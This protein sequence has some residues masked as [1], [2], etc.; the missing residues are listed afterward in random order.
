MDEDEKIKVWKDEAAMNG[1]IIKDEVKVKDLKKLTKDLKKS[2]RD[3]YAPG[4]SFIQDQ[5][6][7]DEQKAHNEFL[8]DLDVVRYEE[9]AEEEYKKHLKKFFKG[10]KC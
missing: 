4:S 1:H 10:D 8:K 5:E 2:A 7:Y 3:Y 9:H 6:E